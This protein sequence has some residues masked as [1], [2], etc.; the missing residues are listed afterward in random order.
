MGCLPSSPPLSPV[1]LG[2]A[3]AKGHPEETSANLDL[4]RAVAVLCVYAAHFLS[5]TAWANFGSLG[6]FG[7]I[8]FFVHTSFVLMAS[9]DRMA[10]T[11]AGPRL[12]YAFALRRFFRIYPLCIATVLVVLL[13]KAPAEPLGSYHWIGWR[14]LASNLAIT[15]SLT[16]SQLS[17]DVLWSLPLEVQMYCL[18]PFMYL[19]IR[20]RRSAAFLFVGMSVAAALTIPKVIGRLVVFSYAPCFSAGVLGYAL[21]KTMKPRLG[22]WIWPFALLTAIAAFNPIDDIDLLHKLPRAWIVSLAVGCAIPFF[23]EVTLKPLRVGAHLIAKYSYGIYLS[24]SVVLW[25]ALKQMA[26]FPTAVRAGVLVAGSIVLPL[27]MY[28]LIEAPAISFGKKFVRRILAP[29]P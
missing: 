20:W 1:S 21:A 29:A 16:Y 3:I 24:H 17:L 23:H 14:D 18:L 9:L 6:R 25:L 5:A 12:F 15:Q 4:L 26:S 27:A 19:A 13:L 2:P 28:H 7:V 10:R 22:A 8:L 11:Y